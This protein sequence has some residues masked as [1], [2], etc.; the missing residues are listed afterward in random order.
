MNHNLVCVCGV[1]GGGVVGVGRNS[2]ESHRV[3][4]VL[5]ITFRSRL[6]FVGQR[7]IHFVVSTP[8]R[9]KVLVCFTLK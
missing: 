8:Y 9:Q 1:C 6:T 3:Y 7:G 2:Q 5:D 4:S